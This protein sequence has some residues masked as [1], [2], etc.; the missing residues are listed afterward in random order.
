MKGDSKNVEFAQKQGAEKISPRSIGMVIVYT[1]HCT[2][3][4][5]RE[6]VG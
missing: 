2:L 5:N 6:M 1:P 4:A 3:R